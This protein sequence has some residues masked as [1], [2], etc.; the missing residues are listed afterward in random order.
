MDSER[1]LP[2]QVDALVRLFYPEPDHLGRLAACDASDMPDAYRQ[3]LDHEHHMTVTVEAFHRDRVNVRVLAKSSSDDS[4]ARKI[5][6]TRAGDDR[7]VQFGIM[8]IHLQYVED[9]VRDAVLAEATP[10]GRILIEHGVFREIH[11]E[12]LW[13]VELGEELAGH[14]THPP[15]S[16]TYGR[17]AT[18]DCNGAPA[19]ELLE[20]VAPVVDD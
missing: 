3:L 9:P 7:V 2:Q 10:L 17:S 6:L 13:R 18:I 11:L 12:Q 1:P 15:G 8:R 4:Y 14:F 20:I 19:I 5:L 16:T